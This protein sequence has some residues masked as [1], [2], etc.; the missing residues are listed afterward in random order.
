MADGVLLL[1]DAFDGLMPIQVCVSKSLEHGLNPFCCY[2]VDRPDTL[3]TR[4]SPQ[5]SIYFYTQSD[6]SRLNFRTLCPS[7]MDGNVDLNVPHGYPS[8]LDSIITTCATPGIIRWPLQMLVTTLDYSD[9]SRH[10]RHRMVFAG[11]SGWWTVT[12]I[13]SHGEHP[14]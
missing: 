4:L 13:S 7:K 5:Y 12:V 2:K 14:S 3:P 9:L 8:M 1:V 11:E 10:N 6:D